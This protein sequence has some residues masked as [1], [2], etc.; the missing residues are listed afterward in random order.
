MHKQKQRERLQTRAG[1][2]KCKRSGLG[3]KGMGRA[4]T[5]G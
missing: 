3:E 1:V 4:E 2:R 5:E